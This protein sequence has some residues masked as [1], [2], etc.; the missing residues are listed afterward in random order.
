[1]QHTLKITTNRFALE[2]NKKKK[3]KQNKKITKNT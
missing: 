2:A 3:K 1:M